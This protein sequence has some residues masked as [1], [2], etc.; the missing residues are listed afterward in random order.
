VKEF[1]VFSSRKTRSCR[2]LVDSKANNGPGSVNIMSPCCQGVFAKCWVSQEL[3]SEQQLDYL[4]WCYR[5]KEARTK[6]KLSK[7]SMGVIHMVVL[8]QLKI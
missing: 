4:R 1:K 7:E 2:L 6:A 5:V 8:S 3:V